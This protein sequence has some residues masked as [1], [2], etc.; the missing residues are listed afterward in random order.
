MQRFFDDFFVFIGISLGLGLA[1][2]TWAKIGQGTAIGQEK[3][4]QVRVL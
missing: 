1:E 4:R 2:V 3:K